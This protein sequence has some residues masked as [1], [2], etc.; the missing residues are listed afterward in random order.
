M[1]QENGDT[2]EENRDY[3]IGIGSS[4]VEQSLRE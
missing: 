1:N 4:E 2:T 3:R